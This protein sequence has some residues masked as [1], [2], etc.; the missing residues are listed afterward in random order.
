MTPSRLLLIAGSRSLGATPEGCAWARGHLTLDLLG[1]RRA[2]DSLGRP[3]V[4]RNV[5]LTGG[6]AGPDV[7]AAEIGRAFGWEV[8]IYRPDG[9]QIGGNR[10]RWGSP[11]GRSAPLARNAAMVRA[12]AKMAAAGWDVAVIGFVDLGSRTQGTAH[13]LGLAEAAGLEVWR[14]CWK[15]ETQAPAELRAEPTGAAA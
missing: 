14:R 7:W 10:S 11:T 2:V 15:A 5:L 6:A 1:R 9:Q 4:P 12:A 13:C 8:V 3:S